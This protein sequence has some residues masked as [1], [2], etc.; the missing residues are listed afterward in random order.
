LRRTSSLDDAFS[1]VRHVNKSGRVTLA[2]GGDDGTTLT[3]HEIAAALHDA[4]RLSD[5]AA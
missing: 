5:E 1:W 3:K 4:D 2:I